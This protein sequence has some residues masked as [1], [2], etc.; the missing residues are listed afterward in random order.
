MDLLRPSVFIRFEPRN[1]LPGH[2]REFGF[3]RLAFEQRAVL[4]QV[5]E[6]F[7]IIVAVRHQLLE[8]G[9]FAGQFLRALR[10]VENLRIAQRSF[11]FGKAL[12]E[13]FDVRT[14][15]HFGFP[16][17]GSI[18]SRKTQMFR[19][20]HCQKEPAHDPSNQHGGRHFRKS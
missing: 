12:A 8:P 9:V 10:V 19:R 20:L 14:Q 1:F 3:R 15:V 16:V 7:Q 18:T 11:D 4:L 5:G 17:C 13:F 6:R 2:L